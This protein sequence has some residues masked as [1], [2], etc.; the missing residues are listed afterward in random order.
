MGKEIAF[1]H[2]LGV[3]RRK[4]IPAIQCRERSVKCIPATQ[5]RERSVK[6]IPAIQCREGSGRVSTVRMR[7]TAERP[8]QQINTSQYSTGWLRNWK[9]TH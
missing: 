7:C 5:W 9:T 4:C 8:A 2:G 6:C 3:Y 1:D